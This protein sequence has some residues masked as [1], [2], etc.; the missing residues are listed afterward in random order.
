VATQR[1]FSWLVN[2][3]AEQPDKRVVANQRERADC[4][5]MET[6]RFFS[7]LVNG[8]ASTCNGESAGVGGL[9]NSGNMMLLHSAGQWFGWTTGQTCGSKS[10]GVSGLLDGGDMMLLL[11]AS[12]GF[13]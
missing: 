1:F 10:A 12:Q 8:L 11:S 4:S 9:I 6:Q 2:G 13:C 3:L 5:T 7:W